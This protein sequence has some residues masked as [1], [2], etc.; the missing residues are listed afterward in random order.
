[1]AKYVLLLCAIVLV[2]LPCCGTALAGHGAESEGQAA[3]SEGG[4]LFS[5]SL[6]DSL[7][8]VVAF[9]ALLLVLTKFAWK[10]LLN[11]LIARQTHIEHQLRT[12]E[13]SRLR[14]EKML[15][16]YKQQGL[17]VIRQAAEQA[18]RH[19]QEMAEKTRQE[20]LAIRHRAQEEIESARA[21]AVED[22]WKQAGDIVLR[23]GSEVLGRTLT[24]QDNQ[25]LAHQA[26][27]KIRQAGGSQ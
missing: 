6:G 7:W 18:Q 27:E 13:D 26:V 8:T 25:A 15:E 16:D 22:L 2:V 4:N 9:F 1:M 12:A 5:G 3:A 24:G 17:G 20:V 19:Q 21:A 10:P 23:V 11:A 14:A